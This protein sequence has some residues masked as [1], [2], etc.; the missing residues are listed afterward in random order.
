MSGQKL[1]VLWRKED[2]APERLAG[3]VVVVIDVLF[4][5]STIVTAFEHGVVDVVP[6]AGPQA[7]RQHAAESGGLPVIL[8]GE[9]NMRRIP[10]FAGYAPLALSREPLSGHRLVYSTTN[11]TVALWQSRS[12]E[13]VYAGTLLNGAAVAKDILR[14]CP[15]RTVLLVCAGSGGAFNLEDCLGAGYIV[16][17][18]AAAAGW[19]LSD[20][21]LAARSVYRQH[22]ADLTA[23]ISACRLGRLLQRVGSSEEL[24]FVARA[25]AF[26]TVPVMRGTRLVR[27]GSADD[28]HLQSEGL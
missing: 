6:A 24:H 15:G 10:G 21:A 27:A 8:A 20:A 18:L 4:A 11:G 16:D 5:T 28:Q 9:H 19:Q 26:G 14:R 7:A 13:R 22:A 1:H 25:G 12:A 17:R 23:A 2:L 3:K